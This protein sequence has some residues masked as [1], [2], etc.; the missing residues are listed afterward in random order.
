MTQC[1][2]AAVIL[3]AFTIL[4]PAEV[5]ADPG[6][7]PDIGASVCA[8]EWTYGDGTCTFDYRS[9]QVRVTVVHE[10]FTE[11]EGTRT[12]S[13]SAQGTGPYTTNS[14]TWTGPF[15]LFS[16]YESH[17]PGYEQCSVYFWALVEV[18]EPCPAPP[19]DPGWGSLLP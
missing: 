17:E 18:H 1:V 5:A 9:T 6:C 15:F 19:P 3:L 16:W 2:H 10:T 11:F 4:V 8:R 12:C 13:P 7:T 14:M